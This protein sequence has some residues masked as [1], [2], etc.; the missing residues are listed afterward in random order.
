MTQ[1]EFNKMLQTAIAGG[2][3]G[4]YYTSQ[5]SGEEIDKKLRGGVIYDY[6]VAG[7][8]TGTE[9]EFQALMG[10]GPWLPLDGGAVTGPVTVIEP[11]TADNPA[12][13]S[14]VDSHGGG[15]MPQ[16]LVFVETGTTVTAINGENSVTAVS[17]NGT[18]VL[19]IPEYGTWTISAEKSGGVASASITIDAVKQYTVTLQFHNVYGVSWDGTSTTKWSRTDG[20]ASFVDPVPYIAGSTSYSSPFDGIQP[21]SGMTKSDRAGGVMVSIPKFWYKLEQNGI[22]LKIQISPTQA[23]GFSVSPAHMDRGDRKGERD[24][25][26]IGR[27]LCGN[28]DYKSR[29]G[30]TPKVNVTRASARSGIH[31]LGS[32]IWQEDFYIIFTIWLLYLVEF[33]DWNSQG[34]I[35]RGGGSGSMQPTGASDMMPYH[36]GTMK[37]SREDPGV[38]VQYRWIE[39]PFGNCYEWYDGCYNNADGLHVVVNPSEFN[40]NA[41][42]VLLGLPSSGY[43]SGFSVASAGGAVLFFPVESLGSTTTYSCDSWAFDGSSPCLCGGSGFTTYD[44]FGLFFIHCYPASYYSGDTSCRLQELP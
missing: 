4:G 35:G 34:C 29:S 19:D 38:G 24:V 42:G 39:D 43:P 36:T 23:D 32:N 9:E 3:V 12:T 40:D 37:N 41:G 2:A 25:V 33:A 11:V 22:G 20:A 31:A 30:Q 14:Y 18:A 15:L 17:Q 44:Y 28:A 13:K 7:G 10:S 5:F 8:Y 27:Y 26:Y 16:I 21:W 1:A 6:A